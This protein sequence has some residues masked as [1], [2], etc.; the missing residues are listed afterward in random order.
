[1]LGELIKSW[2]WKHELG[3]AAAADK[4]GITTSVLSNIE[5][6]KSVSGETMLALI[7]VLF[8]RKDAP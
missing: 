6:G 3:Q 8:S 7:K 5:A 1:M 2:R 4:L